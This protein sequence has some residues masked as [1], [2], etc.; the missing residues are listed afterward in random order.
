MKNS[1]IVRRVS[2]YSMIVWC[3]LLGMQYKDALVKQQLLPVQH[4]QEKTT[5]IA[6]RSLILQGSL[7]DKIK[8]AVCKTEEPALCAAQ[9]VEPVQ[10]CKEVTVYAPDGK[11]YAW[12]ING[13]LAIGDKDESLPTYILSHQ[14]VECVAFDN[15]TL[16][17]VTI[18]ERDQARV[19]TLYEFNDEH[20][21]FQYKTAVKLPEFNVSQE[22]NSITL[23]ALKSNLGFFLKIIDDG[24]RTHLLFYLC[25]KGTLKKSAQLKL[26]HYEIGDDVYEVPE[27]ADSYVVVPRKND[28][29]FVNISTGDIK[30]YPALLVQK[31]VIGIDR[32]TIVALDNEKILFK[33][34]VAEKNPRKTILAHRIDNVSVDTKVRPRNEVSGYFASDTNETLEP[35]EKLL[36]I[37][38]INLTNDTYCLLSTTNKEIV[39]WYP[40]S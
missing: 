15:S 18:E 35:E 22:E 8:P 40:L 27:P 34:N 1:M 12:L 7:H 2:G 33:V 24:N 23:K 16:S 14:E 32:H 10:E 29:L 39:A 37:Q 9:I 4:A 21:K 25:D 26:L 30:E 11:T 5:A 31:S 38:E 6:P 3:S 28:C 20:K 36:E 19:I 13:L 17:L